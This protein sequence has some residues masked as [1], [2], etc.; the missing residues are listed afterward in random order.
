M[1]DNELLMR[2]DERTQRIDERQEEMFASI[3]QL[4]KTVFTGNGQPPLTERVGALETQIAQLT[5]TCTECRRIVYGS[6]SA[7]KKPDTGLAVVA[8]A[9]IAANADVKKMITVE[10]WKFWAAV[11]SG[12]FGLIAAVLAF[13][14]QLPR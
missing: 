12:I 1:G 10:S 14:N 11:V 4:N 9:A 8:K 6:P 13:L 3:T 2:I 7:E 5:V